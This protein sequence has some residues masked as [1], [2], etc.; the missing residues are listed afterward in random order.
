LSFV[1]I[2]QRANASAQYGKATPVQR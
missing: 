1:R 2:I